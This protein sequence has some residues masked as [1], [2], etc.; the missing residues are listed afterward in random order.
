MEI[1]AEAPREVTSV[2][3]CQ[4]AAPLEV[5]TVV[6]LLEAEVTSGEAEVTSQ[7]TSEVTE[8]TSQV[9]EVTSQVASS[10][11]ALVEAQTWV[12]AEVMEIQWSMTTKNERL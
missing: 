1:C 10:E 2:V 12:H 11:E 4:I 7:L 6:D 3:V 8:S 9:V 5:S